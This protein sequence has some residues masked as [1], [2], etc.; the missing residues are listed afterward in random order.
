MAVGMIAFLTFVFFTAFALPV[1]KVVVSSVLVN[2]TAAENGV[3][4]SLAGYIGIL[5][6]KMVF[7]GL[8]NSILY[9]AVGTLI[10]TIATVLSAYA[11]SRPDFRTAEFLTLLFVFTNYFSGGF[12]PTYLLV[13]QLG[14]LN[15]MWSLILP[16]ALSVYNL[17]LLKSYFR[18]KIP[19]E[20]YDAARIDG[21]GH[22]KYLCLIVL[23]F[24]MSYIGVIAFFFAVSYWNAYFNASIYITDMD[25][26]PLTNILRELLIKNQES[27]A[28]QRGVVT[29]TGI[30]L[31]QQARLMEYALVVIAS[32]PMIVLLLVIRKVFKNQDLMGGIKM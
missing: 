28:L 9:T 21:C 17:L 13:K 6:N 3:H 12:V 5:E 29:D 27:L 15:S 22:W 18:N 31:V 25:K 11:L 8:K 23:P 19:M 2:D 32:A 1:I 14:L 4:F 10:S 7:Q 20:L 26:L 30:S 16:S 24:S